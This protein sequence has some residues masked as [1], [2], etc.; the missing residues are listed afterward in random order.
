MMEEG[1]GGVVEEGCKMDGD[2]L[3]NGLLLAVMM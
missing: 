1:A 3:S 2:L